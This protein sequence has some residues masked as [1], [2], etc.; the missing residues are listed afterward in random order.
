MITSRA[1]E[2]S[3]SLL[4]FIITS[5]FGVSNANCTDI[6]AVELSD[7]HSFAEL[8]GRSFNTSNLQKNKCIDQEKLKQGIAA[9]SDEYLS[10]LE[11]LKS[12]LSCQMDISQ[13]RPFGHAPQTFD[14]GNAA[15]T[16]RNAAIAVARS[17]YRATEKIDE[18]K[19]EKAFD[20][21]TESMVREFSFSV[22]F[23]ETLG[24]GSELVGAIVTSRVFAGGASNSGLLKVAQKKLEQIS[25]QQLSKGIRKRT[26]EF[27]KKR[28]EK[29]VGSLKRLAKYEKKVEDLV[30]ASDGGV[31]E[32]VSK[33][34]RVGN[35]QR[36]FQNHKVMAKLGST[37]AVFGV[38]GVLPAV[39]VGLAIEGVPRAVSTWKGAS[40]RN[41]IRGYKK[42]DGRTSMGASESHSG[43]AINNESNYYSRWRP[44]FKNKKDQR[45][46]DS[47]EDS[48][49]VCT[50]I[51]HIESNKM[52][53]LTTFGPQ[54]TKELATDPA[55]CDY[56][57]KLVKNVSRERRNSQLE[58]SCDGKKNDGYFTASL[59]LNNDPAGRHIFGDP[60]EIKYSLGQDGNFAAEKLVSP[61]GYHPKHIKA[62]KLKFQGVSLNPQADIKNW[63]N[64]SNP[65]SRSCSNKK[66]SRSRS[67][68]RHCQSYDIFQDS[69][70]ESDYG[71]TVLINKCAIASN[72]NNCKSNVAIH[73]SLRPYITEKT[74]GEEIGGVDPLAKL[75]KLGP[76]AF[77]LAQYSKRVMIHSR[78]Y[79]ST[80][81]EIGICCRLQSHPSFQ[82]SRIG[83]TCRKKYNMNN[84]AERQTHPNEVSY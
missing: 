34:H 24:E 9:P 18:I 5:F 54:L 62:M 46:H 1:S 23:L 53:N 63:F 7:I 19:I 50:V 83:D 29:V 27:E 82:T 38:A 3:Y 39:A 71:R 68:Q 49:K 31:R 59:R 21:I 42:C 44:V 22:A 45:R 66:L 78:R 75:E 6:S 25:K 74:Y 79:N 30:A 36:F 77:Q 11:E 80:I 72:T 37:L 2:L 65:R 13:C 84:A 43:Y 81:K 70:A 4:F 16:A 26:A 17:L 35:L 60:V 48:S 69:F 51:P 10:M 52:E 33:K 56:V 32:K 58:A 64:E 55:I 73:K 67:R 14:A 57:D 28:L 8:K 15:Q 40:A 20:N 47:Q 61:A 12:D 76:N 41:R